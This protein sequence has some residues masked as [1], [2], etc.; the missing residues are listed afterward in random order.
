MRW[1]KNIGSSKTKTKKRAGVA[2][3]NRASSLETLVSFLYLLILINHKGSLSIFRCLNVALGFLSHLTIP[4]EGF[5]RLRVM[6]FP[7]S[8]VGWLFISYKCSTA[9]WDHGKNRFFHWFFFPIG[10]R[11][12]KCD[13][14]AH[15]PKKRLPKTRH[16]GTGTKQK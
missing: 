11:E 4:T 16:E 1:G 12:I 2:V 15:Y 8:V 6:W 10:T 5:V 7:F 3:Y 14:N 13:F 9:R